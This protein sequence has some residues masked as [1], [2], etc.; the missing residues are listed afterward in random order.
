MG[1][2]GDQLHAF[3]QECGIRFDKILRKVTID[4][5]RDLMLATSG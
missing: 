2:F 4:I 5:T 1:G 3:A